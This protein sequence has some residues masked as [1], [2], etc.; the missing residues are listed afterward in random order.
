VLL[1]PEATQ[2]TVLLKAQLK[3]EERIRILIT[4]LNVEKVEIPP[5]VT[6]SEEIA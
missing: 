3:R 6:K 2:L 4:C 1:A 5:I